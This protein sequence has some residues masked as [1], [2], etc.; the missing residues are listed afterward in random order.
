[1]YVCS[2]SLMV[3]SFIWDASRVVRF[4]MV[5]TTC[6]SGCFELLFSRKKRFWQHIGWATFCDFSMIFSLGNTFIMYITFFI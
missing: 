1:M 2:V 3:F 6:Q 4:F 5:C